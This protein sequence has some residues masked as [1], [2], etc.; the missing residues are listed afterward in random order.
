MCFRKCLVA[1]GLTLLWLPA[2]LSAQSGWKVVNDR[3][4]S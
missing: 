4:N 3:T 1:F 2:S